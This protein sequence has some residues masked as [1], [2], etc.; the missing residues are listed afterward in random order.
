MPARIMV[1]AGKPHLIN[2]IPYTLI[3]TKGTELAYLS[4]ATES[5][6]LID[7]FDEVIAAAEVW[8]RE[9]APPVRARLDRN[10]FPDNSTANSCPPLN[11]AS[12]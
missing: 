9:M 8:R 7:G 1:R 4:V 5:D 10:V 12:G 6:G 2:G 11:Q 3:T